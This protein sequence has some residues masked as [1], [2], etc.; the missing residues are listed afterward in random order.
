MSNLIKLNITRLLKE[1][2]YLK[3]D[4]DYKSEVASQIDSEFMKNVD[5]I[6]GLNPE[7]KELYLKEEIKYTASINEQLE[8][9]IE[10]T[11]I[12]H[13]EHTKEEKSL[14]RQIVKL[15]HPDKIE[16][17]NLNSLYLEATKA[18]NSG[19]IIDLVHICNQLGLKYSEDL[20]DPIDIQKEINSIKEHIKF[21]C[22]TYTWRWNESEEYDKRNELVLEFIKQKIF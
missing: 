12:E 13:I 8:N 2:D 11:D 6:L 22:S 16:D 21:I 18:Y 19:S 1:L 15:T 7:L 10:E 5:R 20:I 17:E 4:F 3:S 9:I 14:Y